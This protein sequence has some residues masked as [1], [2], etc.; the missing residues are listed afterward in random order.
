[1]EQL[2]VGIVGAAGRGRSFFSAFIHNPYTRLEALCDINQEGLL[3]TAADICVEKTYT[4]YEEML[5]KGG[6]D[7]VMI[8]TPMQYHAE[9]AIMALKRDKHV[10]SEVPA[11]V[12]MEE[13]RALVA[14]AKRSRGKYMMAENYCYIRAN[15]LVKAIADRGLFGQMYFGEGEYIHEL[16]GL[17]EVTKW[18]RKWQTGVNGATY[19]THSLG[20]VYQWMNERVTS[21]LCVGTGHHYLDPRGDA[22]ENEDSI[23]LLCRM[24]KGGLINVRVDMLSD[25]PHK[26]DYYS[27]QGTTGCYESSRKWDDKPTIWLRELSEEHKW[28][29]LEELEEKFL[30]ENWLH[31]SDEAKA[32]GHWGGDY[33]EVM[34]FV[35]AIVNDEEPPIG[36]HQAMDMSNPGLISQESIAQGGVWVDVP[37]TREW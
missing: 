35:Q 28:F 10:L 21:V 31:M 25:R 2:R 24:A 37:D 34:D 17:N 8:G 33:M 26:M 19:P 6:L 32:S 1:M 23:T 13:S 14:A 9:Q 12:S 30:P 7:I 22:Y 11:T 18:R 27:L 4:D 36:I 5:E 29:P 3:K 15:V 20:P 16:K